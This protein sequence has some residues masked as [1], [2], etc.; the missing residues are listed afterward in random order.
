MA[1]YG[2]RRDLANSRLKIEVA[3][4]EA[5]RLT[6]AG[7]VTLFGGALTIDSGGLTMV[8]ASNVTLPAATIA[9]TAI[10]N[11]N[12]SHITT[13]ADVNILG[14][15]A[16]LYR[17]TTAG[18]AAGEKINVT[19]AQKIRVIDVWCKPNAAGAGAD[20]IIVSAA[21]SAITDAMALGAANTIVRAAVLNDANWDVAAAS[22]LRVVQADGDNNPITDVYVLAIRVA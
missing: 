14:A 5:M 13:A 10:K 17:I 19:M 4:T 18:T 21:G 7:A 2:F 9:S 16:L 6:A 20:S 11:I 3:G 12:S 1:G 22:A 8:G 15:P